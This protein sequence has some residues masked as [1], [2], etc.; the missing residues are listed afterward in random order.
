MHV[1]GNAAPIL[2]CCC[3]SD[4]NSV[5]SIASDDAKW[6]PVEQKDLQAINLHPSIKN[7]SK[8]SLHRY[9]GHAHNSS[10]LG[11]YGRRV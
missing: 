1:D 6:G 11:S 2:D 8:N 4:R 10:S 9:H 7:H 5:A 3:L